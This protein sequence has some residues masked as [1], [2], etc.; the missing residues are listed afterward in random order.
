MR[1]C[2][3]DC[4]VIK[5][6]IRRFITTLNW[7][8]FVRQMVFDALSR[9]LSQRWLRWLS[10]KGISRYGI[11]HPFGKQK[12]PVRRL[13]HVNTLLFSRVHQG[14]KWSH[15]KKNCS[16]KWQQLH[17]TF[18]QT[19]TEWVDVD[20]VSFNRNMATQSARHDLFQ[21]AGSPWWD[22]ARIYNC[23]WEVQLDGTNKK[24]S[25]NT[26]ARKNRKQTP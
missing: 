23:L 10:G 20:E 3:W 9:L 18:A 14:P 16:Q 15:E 4:T 19:S 25:T 17:L 26:A 12:R 1:D 13:G 5:C 8:L 6:T 7:R 21:S 22:A 24:A 2:L 11:H